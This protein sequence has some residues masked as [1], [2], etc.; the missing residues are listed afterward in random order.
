MGKPITITSAYRTPEYNVKVGGAKKS[1]HTERKAMDVLW[2]TSSQQGRVD[3]IQ[4]AIDA[5]FT[6]IG[7]YENFMHVDIGPKRQWGPSGSK[8]TQYATYKPI[9]S[10]NGFAIV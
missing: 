3:M 6:G 4:R 2:G 7:C 1:M 10:A 9:L 5:G 8:S